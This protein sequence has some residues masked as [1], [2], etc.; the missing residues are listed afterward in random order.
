M[1]Y[2]RDVS[3]NLIN[4]DWP[5][6][7]LKTVSVTACITLS[8]YLGTHFFTSLNPNVGAG[9]VGIC[10]L[11]SQLVYEIFEEIKEPINSKPIAKAITAVQLL[12]F[13]L[14]FYFLHGTHPFLSAAT[15]LEIISAT[16]Y[17]IA[18]PIFFYFANAALNDPTDSNIATAVGILIPL[19][20]KLASYAQAFK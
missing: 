16:A 2:I 19:A 13:P 9:Y 18:I 20:S 15:K 8:G 5:Q 12:Q 4:K 14:V 10:I 3:S 11:A 6:F 7:V 1:N 17:F